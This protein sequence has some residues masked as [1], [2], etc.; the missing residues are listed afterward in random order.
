MIRF[1]RA[2]FALAAAMLATTAPLAQAQSSGLDSRVGWYGDLA[3]GAS[4]YE[5]EP[6]FITCRCRKA[7]ATAFKVGAGYRFGLVAAEA[8]YW[9]L[10]KANFDADG[11]GPA[12]SA[13][14]RAAVLSAALGARWGQ[15]VEANWR[16][17]AAFVHSSA[18]GNTKHDVR[19]TAGFSIGWRTSETAT[20]E[21]GFDYVRATDASG[22]STDAVPIMLGFRQRF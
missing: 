11:H 20:V 7:T 1:K 17:G 12:T 2:S 15:Y 13:H 19:P 18:G 16:V 5:S 8:W 22:A 21:L 9:D 4:S 10:G 3:V 6:G 14:F